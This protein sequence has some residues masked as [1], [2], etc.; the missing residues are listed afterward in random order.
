VAVSL[1]SGGTTVSC[2]VD[3]ASQSPTCN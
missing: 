3:L 2:T 1:A